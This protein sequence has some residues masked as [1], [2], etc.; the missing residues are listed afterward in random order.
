M[1]SG[2]GACEIDQSEINTETKVIFEGLTLMAEGIWNESVYRVMTVSN[3]LHRG[4]KI[5]ETTA[6]KIHRRIIVPNSS[7]DGFPEKSGVSCVF[8]HFNR[9]T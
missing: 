9:I 5:T 3:T 7:N 6:T 2:K 1:L 8:V 4:L